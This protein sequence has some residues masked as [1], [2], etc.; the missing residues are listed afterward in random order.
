MRGHL[1]V[2]NPLLTSVVVKLPLRV[3][4]RLSTVFADGS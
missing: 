3:T 2:K 4:Y 1:N